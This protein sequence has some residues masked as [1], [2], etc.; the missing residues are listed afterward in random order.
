[1]TCN[2]G[3]ASHG[4]L[5]PGA[6]TMAGNPKFRAIAGSAG[7]ACESSWTPDE[8]LSVIL[9]GLDLIK[10][11]GVCVADQYII[12]DQALYTDTSCSYRQLN[13]AVFKL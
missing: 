7:G 9:M 13:A 8:M 3:Q 12:M 11:K 6:L 1:M 4:D 5:V 2:H 10:E